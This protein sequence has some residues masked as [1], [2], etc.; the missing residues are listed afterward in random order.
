MDNRAS[1]SDAPWTC[2]RA[3]VF[4]LRQIF[5]SLFET[6]DAAVL[7]RGRES[8]NASEVDGHQGGEIREVKKEFEPRQLEHTAVGHCVAC[9]TP[10]KGICP[11]CGPFWFDPC[12]AVV[13]EF[14][15]ATRGMQGK[16]FYAVR[17]GVR[18]GL[19]TTWKECE[20]VVKYFSGAEFKGF[21]VYSGVV[22]YLEE[23]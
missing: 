9:A 3:I 19:Y 14:K 21:Q 12:P 2:L 17:K 18:P 20:A 13:V 5:V 8:N 11:S 15:K 4:L 1:L 16:K 23:Q 6:V 22:R 10:P 7:R